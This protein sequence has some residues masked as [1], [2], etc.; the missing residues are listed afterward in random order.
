MKKKCKLILLHIL[1]FAAGTLYVL[2]GC[3]FMKIFGFPCPFCGMTRA[4]E[5]LFRLDI[6][7]AF[8]WHPLF[9]LGVPTLLYAA[10]RR[11]VRRKLG[12][13]ADT[14]ILCAIGA[15]FAVTYVIRIVI[16]TLPY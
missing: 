13:T 5:A 8:Y 2:W 11:V 3:P 1:I 7:E 16:G 14:I 12:K 4:Y 15:A 6:T 10:H 9:W